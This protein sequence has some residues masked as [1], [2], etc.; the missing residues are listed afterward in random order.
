MSR[1]R[2]SVQLLGDLFETIV[3]FR[4]CSL[5]KA[6]DYYQEHCTPANLT[7]Y[8]QY[9]LIDVKEGLTLGYMTAGGVGWWD[10]IGNFE[11]HHVQKEASGLQPTKS[12]GAK[13]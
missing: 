9:S 12:G 4:S 7:T 11:F 8:Q 5:K 13:G 6:L 2:Y 1:H 3:L 10:G